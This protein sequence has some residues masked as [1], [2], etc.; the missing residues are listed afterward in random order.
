MKPIGYKWVFVKNQNMN[1]EIV[2]Y[3]G[4]FVA[5][6]FSQRPKIFFYETYPHVVDAIK[7]LY[8]II[9][10]AHE[11][12]NLK[13]MDIVTTYLHDLIDSDIYMKLPTRFNISETHYFE[14]PESYFIKLNK[15]LYGLK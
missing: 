11:W 1:G 6:W 4:S 7:F 10:V 8:L 2:R 3:K 5:Q 12:L 9:I 14:S 15:S 13:M